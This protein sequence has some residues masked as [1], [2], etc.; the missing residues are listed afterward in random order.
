MSRH[1]SDEEKRLIL[2]RLILNGGDVALTSAEAGISD[3]TLYNWCRNANLQLPK[4]LKLPKFPQQNTQSDP[5]GTG[6]FPS[7]PTGEETPDPLEPFIPAMVAKAS[8]LLDSIDEA[9]QDAPLNQRVAALVQLIDRIERMRFRRA[10]R[11]LRPPG[12]DVQI[13][14]EY[15]VEGHVEKEDD[16]DDN[17]LDQAEDQTPDTPPEPAHRA[18][19]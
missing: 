17:P 12:E 3:R 19:E 16:L 10:F 2:D 9:I 1:Y 6:F 5:V 11:P 15:E 8:D 14:Y 4:L 13:V 7:D 18:E